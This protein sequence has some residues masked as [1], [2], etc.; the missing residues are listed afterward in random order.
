MELGD[1]ANSIIMRKQKRYF[2][3]GCKCKSLT[4]TRTK[5]FN[6]CQ[7]GTSALMYLGIMMQ[8]NDNY[9][10]QLDTFNFVIYYFKN[11]L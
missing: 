7:D 11:E 8:N 9:V 5:F 4:S 2:V 6:L 1:T 3:D 10:K